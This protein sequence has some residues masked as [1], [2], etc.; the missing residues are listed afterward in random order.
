MG[1]KQE[2]LDLVSRK[3]FLDYP[4]N[5]FIYLYEKRLYENKRMEPDITI[6][7]KE[8]RECVCLVEIGYTRPE[9][10]SFYRNKMGVFDVRWYDK[11]G[12]LHG[13]VKEVSIKAKYDVILPQNL[14]VYYITHNIECCDDDCDIDSMRW[15]FPFEGG[16]SKEEL[17][18]IKEK[19]FLQDD[20][21]YH[22]YLQDR[23]E[24]TN[25]YL[26]TD[27][28]KAWVFGFCDKCGSVFEAYDP[29]I[30]TCNTSI[31]WFDISN[32]SDISLD[33]QGIFDWHGAHDFLRE[34]GYGKIKWSEGY[35][36]PEGAKDIDKNGLKRTVTEIVAEMV[37]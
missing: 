36:L 15:I 4:K 28:Y 7:N 31:D 34:K 5:D 19:M 32:P 16:G 37:Y 23:I 2:L 13:D 21:R 6:R 35:L 22:E 10:L 30:T 8:T 26:V 9:K 24:E 25:G 20:D 3:L 12:I 1:H 18:Q 14:Y 11:T 33:L 17:E 27:F 29:E